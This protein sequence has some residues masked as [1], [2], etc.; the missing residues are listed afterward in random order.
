MKPDA[1][2]VNT[3][4]G[5]VVDQEALA[6]A[7]ESGHLGGAA[8]DVFEVEPLAADSRLRTME[9]VILTPHHA[10]YSIESIQGLREEVCAN[11][12]EWIATGW[13]SNVRNPEVRDHLRPR[14]A[15]V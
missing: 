14:L 2:L 3:S 11:V 12:A 13:A 10:S 7:L 8:L 5:P 4:R 6:D 1:M 15:A 9:H